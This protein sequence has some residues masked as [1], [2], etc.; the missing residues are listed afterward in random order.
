M[1]SVAFMTLGCK[2]N[3]Y[4]TESMM[5][6]FEGKGYDIV[7]FSEQAD[8][9][10]VNTCTVTN[11]ADKK[12]RQMLSKAKKKNNEALVVAVGCYVQAAEDA[13]AAVPNVDLLVG[14]TDKGRIADVVEA[15][16]DDALVPKIE[17]LSRYRTYDA[18]WLTHESGNTRAHIKIQD[19][20][21]QFCTY[22]IIPFA[23]GRIRS[24][25]KESILEEVTGLVARGYKEI[26]LT[27]IH[28]AS[29]GVQ[30]EGYR[31]IDLLEDL[32]AIDGLERVR[33]GSVEPTLV[34]DAFV[35]RLSKLPSVCDHFH[36]SMQSGDDD[37]L[38]AMNR[39]YTTDDYYKAVQRLR[40]HFP[41]CGITTDLIVGFPGET[42][43][44]FGNTMAF[45]RKVGFSDLHVFKYSMRDGTKAAK[46]PH[47]ID[48]AIKQTRSQQAMNLGRQMQ[49]A[50]LERFIDENLEVILEEH[51]TVD[52]EPYITGHTSNF[53]KVYLKAHPALEPG[54][55]I[56]V[57]GKGLKKDGIE[58]KY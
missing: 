53:I 6:Q 56:K 55:I 29:Y 8:V 18:L 54:Q 13:L 57:K 34:D 4:E 39:K 32:D 21:D 17:D 20:C 43:A 27:G 10:I 51:V 42:E 12:S 15:Y 16:M 19:G 35:T 52:E 31:L 38:R 50:F 11:M 2:V 30:F 40:Q 37:V 48:G 22:C 24:R 36:L 1:A 9:Y 25:E 14:N 7:G 46:M 5:A 28:I 49:T 47:Q 3:Q 58:A 41:N 33:L 23:R 44:M 26:V 45:L